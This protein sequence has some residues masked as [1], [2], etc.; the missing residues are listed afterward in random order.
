MVKSLASCGV[1]EAVRVDAATTGVRVCEYGATLEAEPCE[2]IRAEHLMTFLVLRVLFQEVLLRHTHAT[3]RTL[4]CSCAGHP[5][6]QSVL[7]LFPPLCAQLISMLLAREALVVRL[8][9]AS[10]T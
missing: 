10:Q 6:Q 9:A 4:F 3:G 1:N 2:A 8:R 5:L 7:I